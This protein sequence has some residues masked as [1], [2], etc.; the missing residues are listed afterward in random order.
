MKMSFSLD[1][2]KQKIPFFTEPVT[3]FKGKEGT[4]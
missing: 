2:P 3:V 4:G 1:T